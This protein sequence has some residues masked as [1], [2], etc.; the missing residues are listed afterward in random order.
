M[1]G[2]TWHTSWF[3]QHQNYETRELLFEHVPDGANG[4]Q[5]FDHMKKPLIIGGK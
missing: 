2:T 1:K 4:V 3:S 5:I